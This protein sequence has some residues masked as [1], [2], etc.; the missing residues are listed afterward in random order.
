MNRNWTSLICASFAVLCFASNATSVQAQ[1]YVNAVVCGYSSY[2][3]GGGCC[4]NPYPVGYAPGYASGYGVGVYPGYECGHR[5]C[6]LFGGSCMRNTGCYPACNPCGYNTCSAYRSFS[7]AARCGGCGG[8]G[9]VC[10][11][12]GCG[13]YGGC[14][15]RRACG[16]RSSYRSCCATPV[17]A[18]NCCS[19]APTC[20]GTAYGNAV[21]SQPGTMT[22]VPAN[23]T[24]APALAP[25]PTPAAPTPAPEPA[26]APQPDAPKPEAPK[27]TT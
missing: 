14:G 9:S 10:G 26:P 18:G 19:P 24:P 23:T 4:R 15:L 8:C 7:Y 11:Y 25:M 6:G 3:S 1:A 5:G 17:I 2:G 21:I 27:P 22:P 13:S 12:S 20:C 16:Y